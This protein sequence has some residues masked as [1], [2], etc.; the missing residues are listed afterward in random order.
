MIN[1]S[2]YTSFIFNQ[3]K[4]L[5][6]LCVLFAQYIDR[7]II[8]L[9]NRIIACSLLDYWL[10]WTFSVAFC[11][12]L[13]FCKQQLNTTVHHLSF[14]RKCRHWVTFL[15]IPK[16]GMKILVDLTF[17]VINWYNTK[18][19]FMLRSQFEYHAI[20][21]GPIK[22]CI[23]WKGNFRFRIS[24]CSLFAAQSNANREAVSF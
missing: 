1:H 5:V 14:S 21:Q 4:L 18:L 11:T 22:T 23:I 16:Y 13:T 2:M 12:T 8:C 6:W 15:F 9:W 10:T 24:D 19:A 7:K 3:C 20:N 17:L